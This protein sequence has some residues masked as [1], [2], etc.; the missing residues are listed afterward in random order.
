M[1]LDFPA[2]PSDGQVFDAPNG[3][4]YAW[5]AEFGVW[6]VA[7]LGPGRSV[8]RQLGRVVPDGTR[9]FIDFI[10]IPADINDLQCFFDL[11]PTTNDDNLRLLF[12]DGDGALI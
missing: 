5:S 11:M 12:Y 3:V 2:N 1:M 8:W 6:L 4:G 7:G 10:D 9:H